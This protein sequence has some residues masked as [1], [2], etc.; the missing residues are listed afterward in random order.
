[1]IYKNTSET[2]FRESDWDSFR[3]VR[4]VLRDCGLSDEEADLYRHPFNRFRYQDPDSPQTFRSEVRSSAEWFCRLFS[5]TNPNPEDGGQA[6]PVDG[7][8]GQINLDNI[9]RDFLALIY[10]HQRC[11]EI[12]RTDRPIEEKLRVLIQKVLIKQEGE[13]VEFTNLNNSLIAVEA[14]FD[15]LMKSGYL[16]D[17]GMSEE[18]K[19][20]TSLI[21]S[22]GPVRHLTLREVP[23]FG[24]MLRDTTHLSRYIR[25]LS[26][27]LQDGGRWEDLIQIRPQDFG[28]NDRFSLLKE[29]RTS[30]PTEMFGRTIAIGREF[31]LWDVNRIHRLPSLR[32]I[33]EKKGVPYL[34]LLRIRIQSQPQPID[35]IDD[36]SLIRTGFSDRM[37]QIFVQDILNGKIIDY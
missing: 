10:Y 9:G 19:E 28:L 3:S 11:S 8:I 17:G 30:H 13:P 2:L 29:R 37:A 26:V 4:Q 12:M 20:G 6:V 18:P 21:L 35:R 32:A 36:L 5:T 27:C 24:Q 34:E 25:N 15:V 22:D 33:S 14:V 31:G 23:S 7:Y 1:M 16:R